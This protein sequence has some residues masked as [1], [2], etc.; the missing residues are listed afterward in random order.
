M[1][2]KNCTIWYSL[3]F[4]IQLDKTLIRI[5]IVYKFSKLNIRLSNYFSLSSDN[6]IPL[7]TA[8]VIVW[9]MISSM[10]I[11]S[12]YLKPA[13]VVP[14]GD[15]TAILKSSGLDLLKS[16]KWRK[17]IILAFSFISL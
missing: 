1:I 14:P 2:I 17:S 10:F 6:S 7:F 8:S 9:V 4:G 12:K 16:T 11:F 5:K 3:E 15:V 13:S